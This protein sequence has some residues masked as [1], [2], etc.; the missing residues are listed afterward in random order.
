MPRTK[1]HIPAQADLSNPDAEDLLVIELR[2]GNG[3]TWTYSAQFAVR[4]VNGADTT[5]PPYVVTGTLGS[6]AVPAAIVA[7]ALAYLQSERGM[8]DGCTESR[9]KTTEGQRC[10]GVT[11][12]FEE[13]PMRAIF[14]EHHPKHAQQYGFVFAAEPDAF[15]RTML[16]CG[17]NDC[18][19]GHRVGQLEHNNAK[20]E[21]KDARTLAKFAGAARRGQAVVEMF[22]PPEYKIGPKVSGVNPTW[23]DCDLHG[24]KDQKATIVGLRH[25]VATLEAEIESLKRERG[26]SAAAN[27]KPRITSLPCDGDYLL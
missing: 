9:T 20:R 24:L 2:P 17:K 12:K 8:A 16:Y 19:W 26:E 7:Q 5:L 15:M 14:E 13:E 27:A 11:M 18:V 10:E 22:N 3:A 21:A 4:D 23:I 1:S 25:R 6:F